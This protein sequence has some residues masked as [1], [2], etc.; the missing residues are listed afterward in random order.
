LFK[1]T[2]VVERM[3]RWKIKDAARDVSFVNGL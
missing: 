3:E 1:T 2:E